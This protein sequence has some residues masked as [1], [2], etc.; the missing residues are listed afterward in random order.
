LVTCPFHGQIILRDEFGTPSRIGDKGKGRAPE[1]RMQEAKGESNEG[2]SRVPFRAYDDEDSFDDVLE[3]VDVGIM[4]EMG[5]ASSSADNVYGQSSSSAAKASVKQAGW[6][7]IEADVTNALGLE[8]IASGKKK[9]KRKGHENSALMNVSKSKEP[10]NSRQ[11]IEKVLS[12]S[13]SRK[14]VNN[15][16]MQL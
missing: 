4:Q 14:H 15:V 3:E 7:E 1:K 10:K 2:P 16:S 12:S 6:E 5:R 11:R 8:K 9:G 13:K